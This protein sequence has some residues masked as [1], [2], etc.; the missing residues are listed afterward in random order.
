[1]K[2]LRSVVNAVFLFLVFLFLWSFVVP[3]YSGGGKSGP[4]F[5][6]MTVEERH[7]LDEHGRPDR[8]SF[9]VP[10]SFVRGSLR[11]A[12]MGTVRREM[13]LHFREEVESEAVRSI[14]TELKEK[15]EGTEVVRDEH[16]DRL[17][18]VR[19][20]S[21]VEMTVLEGALEPPRV[22][23]LPELPE[24]PAIPGTPGM[25][26]LPGTPGTPGT[27]A[28]PSTPEAPATT[29]A[30]EAVTPPEEPARPAAP[31]A[32]VTIRF[33]FRLL[34]AIASEERDFDVDTLLELLPQ[35]GKGEVLSVEAPEASVRVWL[36]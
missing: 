10:Y 18:F 24:V 27:P 12:A 26:A 23:E 1:M 14:W 29:E 34:E 4:R 11:L 3:G 9:S 33:P 16:D 6:R 13:D 32:K 36:E 7:A 5:L 35:A 15:P 8:V 2:E 17:V 30:P 21:M 19:K 20:G 22:P 28:T 25:P 31:E